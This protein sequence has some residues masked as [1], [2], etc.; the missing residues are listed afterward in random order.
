MSNHIYPQTI[1]TARPD[2]EVALQGFLLTR[3]QY[4]SGGRCCFDFWIQTLSGNSLVT[5]PNQKPTCFVKA[6]DADRLHQLLQREGLQAEIKNVELKSFKREPMSAVYTVS[7]N[8]YYKLKTLCQAS[9]VELFEDD[10]RPVDRYLM[11]R[12]IKGGVRFVGEPT[13]RNGYIHYQNGKMAAQLITPQP[14][15]L[16][17]IDIECNE[18]GELF[19]IGFYSEAYQ[20]VLYNTAGMLVP[21]PMNPSEGQSTLHNEPVPSYITWCQSEREL[22]QSFVNIVNDLDPDCLVG[23]NFIGFDVRLIVKAAKRCNV[24][25]SI[26]RDGSELR[27]QDGNVGSQRFPDRASVAGRIVL[28][29]IDVM[30]NATYHFASFSL[31]NVAKVIL[32][33]QKIPLV[34]EAGDKLAEI[35][36]LY[37]NEPLKLAAYNLQ[38]CKLVADIFK[39]EQLLLYLQ[40]RTQLTGLDLD[41]TGGSVA[42][43]HNLYMPDMHRKGWIA[44]NLVSM[45]D[46]LHSPGGFVMDSVPGIHE[47]V[48]VFDFK[49]LYPS[50]IRTF[51]VD[52]ITLI[53]SSEIEPELRLPG[54]RGGE[55][56]RNKS[57]L[58]DILDELWVAREK[59]KASGN[60]VFSNA[61]KIIM[62]SFYGV[63]GSAGCR[64]YDTKLASSITMRGHWVLN[65]TKAWFHQ[66]GMSV[67]YGDTDSVFVSLAGS[68]YQESD[69]E[70]LGLELN[71]W[72]QKKLRQDFDIESKLELEY[73]NCYQPF[74]MPKL[75]GSDTGSKKRYA[76]QIIDQSGQ[77]Q[78]VFKGLENVRSD[79]T[80]MAKEFQH[81]LF[82]RVFANQLC[83]PYIAETIQKLRNGEFDHLL[84]YKKRI[85]NELVS[86]VKTTPPQIRAARNAN[87]MLG[88]EKY[89]KG[90]LIEYFIST[91]GPKSIDE[92]GHLDYQHYVEKQLFP[93]A[94]SILNEHENSALK[95]FSNQLTLL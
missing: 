18:R 9:N 65:E 20:A 93:I 86:Y 91:D 56:S 4:D 60:K 95:E 62:N 44:P 76:G 90:S 48:L 80:P 71:E 66:R 39:Q 1:S 40:T 69:A 61:I 45:E 8:H 83:Q 49:S 6:S 55:F 33:D 78:I 70:Q 10:I 25:L 63:L 75:R 53:E 67:I 58:S 13:Q 46:Y 94:E 12:F 19:S 43:F 28:D 26:G 84:N 35:K 27:F 17:S 34:D 29:G 87:K 23:W 52:P 64:F 77:K 92:T 7:L 14:F 37:Q 15:S 42:A 11:E 79:W 32:A 54:F 2:S 38:D 41:K 5:V 21:V 74:F 30:K 47:Q 72:W 73:E 22:L 81:E 68:A 36:R 59:A 57:L 82:K 31:N 51:N 50:I 85:R 24:N 3:H 16:L 88:Y 89:Q